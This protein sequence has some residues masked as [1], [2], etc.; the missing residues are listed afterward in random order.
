MRRRR[1][2]TLLGSAVTW[3]LISQAQQEH[4]HIAGGGPFMTDDPYRQYRKA[5]L[6]AYYFGLLSGFAN[7]FDRKKRL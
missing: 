3:P 1:F 5:M 7:T 6:E 4:P 2:L